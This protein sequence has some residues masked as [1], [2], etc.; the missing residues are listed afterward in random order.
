MKSHRSKKSL[1]VFWLYCESFKHWASTLEKWYTTDGNIKS[2]FVWNDLSRK[3]RNH[4]M[5][6]IE[7]TYFNEP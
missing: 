5:G 1:K 3:Q 2:E 4:Y 7:R 6:L